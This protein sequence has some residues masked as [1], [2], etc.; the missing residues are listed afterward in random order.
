MKALWGSRNAKVRIVAGVTLLVFLVF[1]S[2]LPGWL[3]LQGADRWVLRIG[4][5]VLGAIAAGIIV[6]FLARQGD[7]EGSQ[8]VDEVE[9][10]LVAARARLASARGSRAAVFGKLP[11]VLVVGPPGCAKTTAVVH[12]GLEPDLLAGEVHHADRISPTGGVNLWYTRDTVLLEVGGRFA[13]DA[14]RWPRLIERIRPHRLAAILTGRPHAPRSVVV[15]FSCDELVKPGPP[16]AVLAAARE[17]RALL[18][19]LAQGF[20]T[21]LPVYALFTKADRLKFFPEYVRNLS[22]DEAQ[23][24]FGATLRWPAHTAAGLYADQEFQR[25]HEALGML[26]QSLAARRLQLLARDGDAEARAGVYE[27]PREFHK[28]TNLV[29]QFLVELCKPSQLQVGPVLRGCYF[30]GVRAVIVSDVGAAP[31]A[32]PAPGAARVGATQL[33]DPRLPL[34]G[35]PAP[36][37]PG[38]RKTAEWLFLGRLFG[39]ILL[40]DRAAATAAQ[41]S[42][43]VH[44]WRRALLA[45]AAAALLVVDFGFIGSCFGDR[46]LAR[47]AAEVSR[48]LTGVV[49]S[50]P[51]LPPEETL[52]GLEAL[53]ELVEGLGGYERG[54]PLRWLRWRPYTGAALYQELRRIYFDRFSTVLLQP[55]RAALLRSLRAVAEAPR[56]AGDYGRTYG[57][58]KAYLMT[59]SQPNRSEPAFLA[60][61]LVERW[62]DG[63]PIDSTRLELARRQFDFF[64]RK[65][66]VAYPCG[67]EVEGPTVARVREFLLSFAGPERIYQAILTEAS[68]RNPS[69]QFNRAFPG[70][71]AVLVDAYEVPGAFTPGGW[72]FLQQ[73]LANVDQFFRSEDWVLGGH[74]RVQLDRRTL[75]PNLRAMYRTDYI[76]HWRTFLSPSAV[77]T[78]ASV[79]DA[80]RKLAR[81]SDPQSPLLQLLALAAQNTAVDPAGIGAAFQPLHLV[82]PPK[83]KDKYIGE[84]NQAY[85]NALVGLR[86]SVEQAAS[87]PSGTA[88]ALVSQTLDGARAA[89]AAVG[90]LALTFRVEGEAAAVGTAVRQVMEEPITRVERLLGRLPTAAVNSRGAAFCNAFRPLRLKYPFNPRAA[91]AATLAEVAALFQPGTG[92]LWRFH[93]EGL[94]NVLVKSGSQYVPVAGGAV[95]PTSAFVAFFNRAAAVS[96]ALWPANASEPRF[97]FTLKPLPSDATPAVT[98]SIDGQTGRFT[99]TAVASRR[100]AWIGAGAREVRLTAQIGGREETLLSFD[101]TWAIFKLLQR[102]NWRTSG[103]G[104]ILGWVVPLQGQAVTLEAELNLGG[105]PPIMRADYLVTLN[106]VSQVAP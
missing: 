52:G 99:R 39:D 2:L 30:T 86:G 18:L 105:V 63:R 14:A 16:E 71:S 90:Q 9:T 70:A 53:R 15:C 55:V 57:L 104:Y 60:P 54:G 26:Y 77:V 100:F 51:E 62:L 35:A 22:R 66:C 8:G 59:T 88:D 102:A 24:V 34:P 27:F 74:A 50:E 41:G 72:E 89:R 76:R 23:D 92:A 7:E 33:L 48:S 69:V 49:S 56:E 61:V 96:D 46:A 82:M 36:A 40:R 103:G 19:R 10:A 28:I 93:D 79:N 20:G 83:M 91:A 95:A 68:A 64:A 78:F 65:L 32:V 75:V 31:P 47:R 38:G 81:L 12:S 29:T 43:H 94:R 58:L 5:W 44:L 6:W 73:A 101:G 80:A 67:G 3:G 106:C 45:A 1:A 84:S 97:D 4:L 21:Q 25:V 13:A 37:G 11:I 17:Y 85:M 42:V 87:A 98:F